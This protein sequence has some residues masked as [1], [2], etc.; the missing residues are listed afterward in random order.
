[1]K[2]IQNWCYA[3]CSA[4]TVH[5]QSCGY[6]WL[7]LY[8]LRNIPIKSAWQKARSVL[9]ALLSLFYK[10]GRPKTTLDE[11]ST[12]LMV[13]LFLGSQLAYMYLVFEANG[14]IL[15]ALHNLSIRPFI[16]GILFLA[17]Q[18]IF[19]SKAR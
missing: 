11:C 15:T 16:R 13:F 3:W 6:V 2:C 18:D 10:K 1:M 5:H 19:R 4:K 7:Y 8:G 14:P 9:G 12:L 17:K